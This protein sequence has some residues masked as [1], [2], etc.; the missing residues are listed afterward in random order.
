VWGGGVH[1]A[2]VLWVGLLGGGGGG[3]TR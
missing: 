2:I 1:G 3:N